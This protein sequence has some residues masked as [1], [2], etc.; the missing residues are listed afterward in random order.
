MPKPIAVPAFDYSIR[1]GS[2]SVDSF[3]T[4]YNSRS[5]ALAKARS[6]LKERRERWRR[7]VRQC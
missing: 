6:A 3:D 1:H 7:A 2:M 5:G 4:R